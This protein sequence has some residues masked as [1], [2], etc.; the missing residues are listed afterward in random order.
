MY[1]QL[2]GCSNTA[3]DAGV[4]SVSIDIEEIVILR[5]HMTLYDVIAVVRRE[6]QSDADA[7]TLDLLMV[8][9]GKSRDNLQSAVANIDEQDLPAGGRSVLDEVVRRA[10]EAGIDDLDYGPPVALPGFRRP[11][12][13]VDEGMGGIAA[14]LG[15]S[16]LLLLAAAVAAV[17]VGLNRIFNWF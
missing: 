7:K 12:E 3:G 11:L 1:T 4:S 15:V 8:E 13:P 6:H 16:S 5:L 2:F 9:L 14:L 10:R 17:V